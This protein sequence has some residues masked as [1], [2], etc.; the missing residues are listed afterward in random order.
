VE[1][2]GGA[3]RR[4]G[5]A[6]QRMRHGAEPAL[7]A[8]IMRGGV[9]GVADEALGVGLA[10]RLGRADA[11]GIRHHLGHLGAGAVPGIHGEEAHVRQIGAH[12][13]GVE[14]GDARR[15]ELL[16]E[17]G[18]DVDQL[19]ERPGDVHERLAG[20]DPVTLGKAE[21]DLELDVTRAGDLAQ[22]VERELR[23]AQHGAAHEHGVGP[24]D[25][26][27][28]LHDLAGLDE[29]LVREPRQLVRGRSHGDGSSSA[30]S[31]A[32]NYG[33]APAVASRT[34]GAWPC[35]APVF[36]RVHARCAPRPRRSPPGPCLA[37]RNLRT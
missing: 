5:V 25:V 11:R 35:A 37:G 19:T 6:D 23:R 24:V 27:E 4:A 8:E 21:L 13:K 15:P 14:G 1:H 20:A 17:H 31:T 33:V 7:V 10:P 36:T 32:P 28:P 16:Q 22:P 29:V 2:L 26:A 12:Q 30:P 34:H 9:G 3:Q 18:L